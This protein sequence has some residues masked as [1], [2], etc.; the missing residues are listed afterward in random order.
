MKNKSTLSHMPRRV[1]ILVAAMLVITCAACAAFYPKII[2]RFSAQYGE[3]WG[4]WME[5]GKASSPD[6]SVQAAGAVFSVDEVLVRD[7]GLYVLGHITAQEGNILIEQ[8][9]NPDDPFGYNV[10]YGETAPERTLTIAQ[11]A[12]QENAAMRYVACY[13]NG[14]GVDGGEVLEPDCWGYAAKVQRDGSIEF[15]MEVEDGLVVEPGTAYT[16]ELC[17]RTWP[18]QQDGSMDYADLTEKTWRITVT[19]EQIKT[20]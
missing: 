13:L 3:S 8:D 11:K 4:A 16:L 20:N 14:I 17:A 19:P 10:H 1:V 9:G 7:R 15:T 5:K 6:A 18:L 2:S 12:Q